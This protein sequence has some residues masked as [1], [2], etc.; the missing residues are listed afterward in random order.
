MTH[1]AKR[2]N[3]VLEA[4]PFDSLGVFPQDKAWLI[5]V[6]LP[7]VDRVRALSIDGTVDYGA[8]DQ[9]GPG[10]FELCVEGADKP[11][12]SLQVEKGK[13]SWRVVDAYQ[14][15][16]RALEDFPCSSDTLYKTM[17][18]Q[19]CSTPTRQGPLHGVRFA[20]YAPNA[21]S[22]SVIGDFNHWDGRIHP[23]QSSED[24]IWRLF[25]PNT[26]SN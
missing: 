25:V 26:S 19:V 23:M 8:M 10:L 3:N 4:R 15:N 14:F 22:V 21:R 5:R 1:L 6:F 2:L 24:G 9:A 7:D 16:E 12:Y 17:G 11:V 18:A 13:D 20:V